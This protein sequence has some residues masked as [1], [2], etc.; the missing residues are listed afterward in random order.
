MGIITVTGTTYAI[1]TTT[2]TQEGT[3]TIETLKCLEL[4]FSN[5][6]NVI[7]LSNTYP[8]LD[9]RGS[10]NTPYTFTLTNKCG[11]YVEYSVGLAINKDNTLE[12][13]YVKTI[14][15]LA[16]D[17]GEPVLLT[18]RVAG[19]V[20][21]NKKTYIFRNDGLENNASKDYK[22]VLWVDES[23]TKNQKGQSFIGNI[24]INTKPI[25]NEGQK[26]ITVDLDGGNLLQELNEIYREGMKIKLPVPAKAGYHFT[27]WEITSGD[28]I[29]DENNYLTIGKENVSLK[30]YYQGG[31]ILTLELNGGSTTQTFNEVYGGGE[32]ITLTEPSKEGSIFAGW[33]IIS[34]D[35]ILDGNVLTINTESVVIEALWQQ[36]WNF[37][38]TG[39]EQT[40]TVPYTGVYKLETWGAQGGNGWYKYSYTNAEGGVGGYS[41]G[42]YFA[43][44]GT[45]LYINVGEQGQKSKMLSSTTEASPTP[46]KSYNGGGRNNSVYSNPYYYANGGGGG[47]THIATKSGLLATLEDNKS[48]ILIVAGGGGGAN[49]SWDKNISE[50]GGYCEYNGGSGGG[51]NGNS[52]ISWSESYEYGL[53]GQQQSISSGTYKGAFGQGADGGT[54]GAGGGGGYYGGNGSKSWGSAGGG[55]GYI[56]NSRLSNKGMYCYNCEESSNESTKTTSVTCSSGFSV[57]TCSKIGNGY[58]RIIF[59][60]KN[61]PTSSTSYEY[62]YTGT[63]QE[64]VVPYTGKYKIELW[65]AQG[66]AEL[67]YNTISHENWVNGGYGGYTK[68]VIALEKGETLYIY[69]GEA[70]SI[71]TNGNNSESTVGQGA[72]ATFNGGGA[73]GNAGGSESLPYH[74]YSGGNSG[75]GATDVRLMSGS[76][77]NVTSLRSRIMVAGGGGGYVDYSEATGPSG[78][79]SSAGGLIS[80]KGCSVV[81]ENGSFLDKAGSLANQTSGNAFGIGGTGSESG[82]AEYCS[83]HSGGGGG[84]YGGGGALNTGYYCYKIGGGGG[85]S[86]ISG[87]TGSVAVKSQTDSSAKSGCTTGTSDNTCSIHYSNKVFTDTVMIDGRGYS[88]TNIKGNLKKMPSPYGYNYDE[89]TGHLGNGYAK[90]SFVS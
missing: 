32:K 23:A 46:Y 62:L 57:E 39:S 74:D 12:D 22:L 51:Y 67:R 34:G 10:K 58:A 21:N 79:L 65:G 31:L 88:W 33:R 80:E 43:K 30:A 77:D 20:Y 6:K 2:T 72:R 40:F 52:G 81:N 73:G 61:V 1:F 71:G 64:F 83:G 53:G 28:A 76:W 35:G 25:K 90:I 78:D 87:H 7:N 70:G 69:V 26:I 41:Y 86:F 42:T 66:G 49:L 85:S 50:N 19:E 55:S 15:S 11:T 37:D 16:N 45:K 27:K 38:F 5:Q 18:D 14:F 59:I 68:G 75:G 89:G 48:S 82:Y 8:M 44:K 4:E 56:G 3:N 29:V 63:V 36:T 9:E 17:T 60:G 13:K 24:I 47:A 84:Y 54:T